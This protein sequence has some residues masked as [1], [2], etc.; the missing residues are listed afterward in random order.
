MPKI[1]LKTNINT[2]KSDNTTIKPFIKDLRTVDKKKKDLEDYKKSQRFGKAVQNIIGQTALD[3]IDF[4]YTQGL[5]NTPKS[6]NLGTKV[7]TLN[8]INDINNYNNKYLGI[9]NAGLNTLKV[10]AP[11]V[12][13]AAINTLQEGIQYYDEE[14]PTNLSKIKNLPQNVQNKI[15]NKPFGYVEQF[16][17]GGKTLKKY[18]PGGLTGSSTFKAAMNKPTNLPLSMSKSNTGASVADTGAG[19]SAGLGLAGSLIPMATSFLPKDTYTDN[20]G[21]VI[22]SVNNLGGDVLNGVAQ[23]ANMGS[24]FGTIGSA[25]GGTLG[26]G[27]G[28]LKNKMGNSEMEDA[29]NRANIRNNNRS[30]SN[31]MLNNNNMFAKQDYNNDNMVFANGGM[32]NINDDMPNATEEVEGGESAITPDGQHIEFDGPTHEMGGIETNLPEGTFIFSDRLKMGKKTFASLAKPIQNKITK[33]E[34]NPSK[35]AKNSKELLTKQLDFLANNQEQIKQETD[36][37]RSLKFANGGMVKYDGGGQTPND[38]LENKGRYMRN[39]YTG[40]V[41]FTPEQLVAER[42]KRKQDDSTSKANIMENWKNTFIPPTNQEQ[43]Q[44]TQKLNNIPNRYYQNNKQ[45]AVVNYRNNQNIERQ[46]VNDELGAQ[47]E[48]MNQ[49]PIVTNNFN[50]TMLNG[51]SLNK[52]NTNIANPN[53]NGFTN[54]RTQVINNNSNIKF[55]PQKSFD[56]RLPVE[57]PQYVPSN[58]AQAEYEALTKTPQGNFYMNNNVSNG[59][60]NTNVSSIE[61]VTTN[62]NSNVNWNEMGQIGASVGSNFIQTNRIDNMA[63]PKTLNNVRLQPG[64]TNPRYV[65]FS[66]QRNAVSRVAKS[67][68]DEAGRNFGNSASIQA[69]KNKARLNE[70]QGLGESYQNQENTNAGIFNQYANQKNEMAAKEAL[71]N[72]EID[73]YNIDAAYGDAASRVSGK[74]AATAQLGNTI[75]QVFGNRTAYKNQ[76]DQA[77]ILKNS[78]NPEVI[79]RAIENGELVYKNGKLEPKAYGGKI[80]K[81]SLKK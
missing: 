23:G 4:S 37:K 54:N 57:N 36:M 67:A 20:E 59:N 49:N 80:K 69:F 38:S 61:P 45:D 8:D 17:Y 56:N 21:N 47:M 5:K 24:S 78:Y 29:K 2:N 52:F 74:N 13:D 46:Q 62:T 26:A 9:I 73:K 42:L 65:N 64:M 41:S 76:L 55:Q 51:R 7:N 28:F 19:L 53:L 14:N 58:N 40:K 11:I 31:R 32:V 77:N 10:P 81:R 27:Y 71:T 1:K 12:G 48:Q 60:S 22:G 72:A 39:K 15:V 50:P 68:M 63:K 18:L 16:K 30:L 33:L 66:G 70:L 35:F 6:F 25:I 43:Q 34:E 79:N 3:Q 44:L 75:G